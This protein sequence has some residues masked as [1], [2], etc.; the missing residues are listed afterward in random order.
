MIL[1]FVWMRQINQHNKRNRKKKKLLKGDINISF[2]GESKSISIGD[3]SVNL[4]NDGGQQKT[5]VGFDILPDLTSRATLSV[6]LI[7]GR[8]IKLG[9]EVVC[10]RAKH[11]GFGRSVV[12][13]DKGNAK[14][15]S[16]GGRLRLL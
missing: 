7:I 12:T 3:I 13:V 4:T 1:S 8:A 11:C 16:Q 15:T 2:F 6:T 10:Q 14:R 9:G 5:H